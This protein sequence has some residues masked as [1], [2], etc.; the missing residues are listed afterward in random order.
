MRLGSGFYPK[1]T[2]YVVVVDAAV[3]F[4]AASEMK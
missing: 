1:E 2:I 4:L 3:C